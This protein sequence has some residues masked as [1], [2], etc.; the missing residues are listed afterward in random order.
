LALSQKETKK[1]LPASRI[2]MSPLRTVT[3]LTMMNPWFQRRNAEKV[4][5]VSRH[6]DTF[7]IAWV[8][9]P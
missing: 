2:G 3:A 1:Q 7:S 5:L 4:Q 6:P 9:F 8:K